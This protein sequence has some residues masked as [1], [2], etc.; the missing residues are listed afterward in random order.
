MLAIV[1]KRIKPKISYLQV[2]NKEKY[3]LIIILSVQKIYIYIYRYM[4]IQFF[5]HV[6]TIWI[7][8]LS[9]GWLIPWHWSPNQNIDIQVCIK[10]DIPLIVSLSYCMGRERLRSSR[11][12]SSTIHLPAD[13]QNFVFVIVIV[14]LYYSKDKSLQRIK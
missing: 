7:K 1:L 8:L 11:L 10:S 6:G 2:T 14:Y 3:H 9:Y 5:S 13:L 4:K 12:R